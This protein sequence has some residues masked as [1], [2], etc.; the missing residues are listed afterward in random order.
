VL[1]RVKHRTVRP[2]PSLQ[3]TAGTADR[4]EQSQAYISLI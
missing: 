4:P 3:P 2:S 1:T